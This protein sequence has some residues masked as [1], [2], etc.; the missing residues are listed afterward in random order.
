MLKKILIILLKI[1]VSASLIFLLLQQKD[2]SLNDIAVQFKTADATWIL[3]GILLFTLSSILGSFQW[4]LL[5]RA[6]GISLPYRRAV[7]YYYVGL[8]FNNFLLGYVA[9][10]AFRI[11]DI[12]KSGGNSTDA[13]STVFIDRFIGFIVLTTLALL[14]SLLWLRHIA[15]TITL[16]MI[17]LIFIGW[18]FAILLLFNQKLAKKF[19]W[20]FQFF[21]SENFFAKLKEI[22]QSANAFRH[23]KKLL[24]I[25]A[26]IS[27]FIQ[28]LR[29]LVHYTAA[30]AAH[31]NHIDLFY[32]F[33]FIPIVALAVSFPI[34]IG[35]FGIRE[36]AAVNLFCLPGV[37]GSP[38]GITS[39]EFMAYLIGVAGSLAGGIIFILRKKHRPQENNE[40]GEDMVAPE[41]VN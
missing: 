17:C 41:L 3:I 33:M 22:Y 18:A 23:Q 38:E 12:S 15:S 14:A 6:R 40:F 20:L 24:L 5:L 39:M 10:D 2:I 34:S 19:K 29:I 36:Q 30:R 9:G 13:V 31:V 37:G 32:F 8:F 28:G 21:L 4:Y 26:L 11:Y 25:T 16:L 27:I 1:L 35:G 7:S